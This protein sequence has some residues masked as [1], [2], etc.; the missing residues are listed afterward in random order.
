[1]KRKLIVPILTILTLLLTVPIFAQSVP[2]SVENNI[3]TNAEQEWP[4]NYRMQKHTI[5]NQTEAYKKLE[6]LNSIEGVPD[7]VLTKIKE[8]AE[9]EWGDNYRMR[10]HTIESQAKAYLELNH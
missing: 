7:N 3:R 10:V 8:K 2:S 1:M 4:D 9:A 5:D 6:N